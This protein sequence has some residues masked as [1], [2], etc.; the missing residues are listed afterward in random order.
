MK[1]LS[2]RQPYAY[3]I[4]IGEKT[5]EYRTWQVNH[6]GPLLIVAASQSD[7][8][9]A[10]DKDGR[11]LPKGVMVCVVDLYDITKDEDGEFEWHLRN[12]RPVYPK[13]I[14]GRL[15]LFEVDDGSIEYIDTAQQPASSPVVPPQK[16]TPTPA[17]EPPKVSSPP[18]I[19]KPVSKIEP[20][21]GNPMPKDSSWKPNQT[22]KVSSVNDP[23]RPYEHQ[24]ASWNALHKHFIQEKKQTGILVVPTGGG[25]TAIATRWLLPHHIQKGG[26]VLWL[27]HR[28]SLL[29]QAFNTFAKAAHLAA[30]KDTL[31]LIAISSQDCNWSQVAKDH[32]VVFSSMQTS[33]GEKGLGFVEL[34]QHQSPKGL[35]VVVDEAHHSSAPSYYQLLTRL[36]GL[37]CQI[38]GLTATPVRMDPK[39]EIRLWNLFREIIY[40]VDKRLLIDKKIL[41]VPH[42]ETVKTKIDFEREFTPE[43]V[44]YLKRFGDLAP[45]VLRRIAAHSSRNKLIVKQYLDHKERYGKTIVFAVDTLHAQTLAKEF[46]DHKITADYVDY[47][48]GNANEIMNQYRTQPSPQVLVNVEMMTEGFD[49]PKTRTVFLT[50]P[51]RSEALLSQ[52]IGRALRG[53]AAGGNKDAYLVTFVDTWERFNPF[54][55][56][57]LV[58]DGEV[59]A[60]EKIKGVAPKI[61]LISDDLIFETYKLVMSNVRGTFEGTYQCFP[62]S[63]YYWDEELEDDIQRRMILVFENQ[64]HGFA[65]LDRDFSD[66]G[67]IPSEVTEA[68]VKGL[69]KTYFS[70]CPDPLP[71][72]DDIRDLLEARKKEAEV[73]HYT[74]EEKKSFDPAVLAQRFLE[75]RLDDTQKMLELKRIFEENAVARSIYREDLRYFLEDVN[76]EVHKMV[77]GSVQD[78]PPPPVVARVPKQTPRPWPQGHAGYDLG[79]ITQSVLSQGKHFPNGAPRYTSIE[80]S[81]APLRNLWGFFRT[82]DNAVVINCV[83]NSPDI[84]LFVLEFLLYHELLHA[85]MPNSGHNADFRDRERRFLPSEKAKGEATALGITPPKGRS[86]AWNLLGDQFL[87]TFEQYYEHKISGE[88]MAK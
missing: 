68:W 64:Q 15:G 80:F 60:P 76:R 41:A 88:R 54:D 58:Q 62:H 66:P 74:F 6:R 10:K 7:D 23:F 39:D 51:T 84:P 77:L 72:W 82:E 49:A 19:S 69:V 5:I 57:Y 55:A 52:M 56:K 67:K 3:E 35:F 73:Y 44:N 70:D 75:K 87:D 50:R 32:D 46:Q 17:Q 47:T 65:A 42:P 71:R 29:R 18:E 1:C 13:P 45:N 63:W 36:R 25:K 27:A 8:P 14:K 31:K 59:A 79:A 78:V 83:L 20:E 33:S 38:L 4:M 81:Q 21:K 48:R 53:E 61:A 11:P 28:N 16:T 85:D 43:D 37:G 26:R 2:V 34:M 12:P 22:L 24:L 86:N 40:Q 9:S 30:P